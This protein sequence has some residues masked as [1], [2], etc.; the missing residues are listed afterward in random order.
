VN[1]DIPERSPNSSS[2]EI[3]LDHVNFRYPTSKTDVLNDVSLI[4]RKGEF[5][6]I[7][8]SAGAGKT[9]LCMAMNGLVPNY[10][11]GNFS[12]KATVK[13]K[14]TLEHPI[15][16]LST[17]VGLIFQDPESQLIMSTVEEE[18]MFGPISHGK[19]MTEALESTHYV[20]KILGITEFL[21]R[22]PQ[23]LSGGQKQRVAIAA[24]LT[25]NPDVLVLDEATSEL[26]PVTVQRVFELCRTFHDQLGKTIIMVSHEIEFLS[27]HAERLVLMDHGRIVLDRAPAEAFKDVDAFK[28]TGVRLPQ[29]TELALSLHEKGIAFGREPPLT[30]EECLQDLKSLL[31]GKRR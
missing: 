28:K 25:V 2:L 11:M 20:A 19:T 30:T 29:V 3:Q 8:G 15:S 12:G 13:G 27:E 1:S 23:T 5:L 9:T 4:V 18:L 10:T 16:E 24:A 6:G 14:S 17:D 21:K 31:S 7:T 22:S 26:D